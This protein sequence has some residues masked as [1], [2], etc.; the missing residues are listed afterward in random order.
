MLFHYLNSPPT[1]TERVSNS[2]SPPSTKETGK[3]IDQDLRNAK[4]LIGSSNAETHKHSLALVLGNDV[5]NPDPLM[6]ELDGL[7]QSSNG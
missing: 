4:L 2:L 1:L 3:K 5:H 6:A 7:V